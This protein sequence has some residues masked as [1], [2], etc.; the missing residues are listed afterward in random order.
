MGKYFP[1]NRKASSE[2]RWVRTHIS[3][4][5]AVH[6]HLHIF[7]VCAY[8]HHAFSTSWGTKIK[9]VLTSSGRTHRAIKGSSYDGSVSSEKINPGFLSPKLQDKIWSGYELGYRLWGHVH[10]TQAETSILK[11]EE[12]STLCPFTHFLTNTGFSLGPVSSSESE[13]SS[14]SEDWGRRNRNWLTED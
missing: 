4:W 1:K 12:Y 13:Y 2:E 10:N 9:N 5:N 7:S 14:Y 6:L 8:H 11:H 3:F